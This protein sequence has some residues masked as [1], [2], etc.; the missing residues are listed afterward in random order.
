MRQVLYFIA[1]AALVTPRPIV[2]EQDLV[3]RLDSTS[4]TCPGRPSEPQWMQE[5][6]IRDAYR[7]VLV[8][9]IYRAQSLARIVEADDCSCEMRFPAWDVAEAEFL[10]RFATA[11]RWEMLE[12]SDA[13]GREANALRPQAMAICEAAGNW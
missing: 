3:P 9:D 10:E 11:E 4:D 1:I 2:A 6:G 8:Q 7:R 12:A 13:Y 5:I